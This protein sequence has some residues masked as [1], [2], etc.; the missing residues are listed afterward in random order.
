MT[1]RGCIRFL[2]GIICNKDLLGSK[3]RI[4]LGNLKGTVYFPQAKRNDYK[5]TDLDM[6]LVAPR[7]FET[8]SKV[9]WGRIHTLPG[10]T[11]IVNTVCYET[12]CTEIEIQQV[13][14]VI[15]GWLTKLDNLLVLRNPYKYCKT[16]RIDMITGENGVLNPNTGIE[17]YRVK[18]ESYHSKYDLVQ[19]CFS[20][21]SINV[22]IIDDKCAITKDEMIKLFDNASS[23]EQI[24][25]S[26][27]LM[28]AAY[29]ACDNGDYRSPIILAGTAMEIAIVDRI[30][31]YCNEEGI[32]ATTI[33]PIGELGKKF[34]KLKE[35]KIPI[36][37]EG[38]QNDLLDIRNSVA[39]KGILYD[40][41]IVHKYLDN[42]RT[43]IDAYETSILDD[44]NV[45][46]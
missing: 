5:P 20:T 44:S 8:F 33:F 40:K 41:S 11:S 3:L 19:D 26:Y 32:D 46:E 36:P 18:Y 2:H 37:V 15:K 1:Y 17:L 25:Q 23:N 34:H 4:R 12:V 7:S 22:E 27:T 16:P 28:L 35:L 10:Y 38:Y 31:Q 30:K 39:H 43:V 6:D 45:E 42:A 13:F 21:M 14:A 9:E 29:H 24:N